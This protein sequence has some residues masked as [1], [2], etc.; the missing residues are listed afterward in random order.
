[1]HPSACDHSWREI[2]VFWISCA[3]PKK[4]GWG[5]SGDLF[6][7]LMLWS[8]LRIVPGEAAFDYA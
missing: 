8:V 1:M 2:K 3:P 5:R 6:L 4:A 7:S